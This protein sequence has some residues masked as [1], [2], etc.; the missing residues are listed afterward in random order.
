MIYDPCLSALYKNNILFFQS[1]N[2]LRSDNGAF[3]RKYYFYPDLNVKIAI[4]TTTI[5]IKARNPTVVKLRLKFAFEN[6]SGLP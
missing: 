3:K 1:P 6:A 4:P 5:R 2:S